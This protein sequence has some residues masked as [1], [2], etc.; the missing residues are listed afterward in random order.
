MYV[1]SRLVTTKPETPRLGAL[2]AWPTLA[3]YVAAIGVAAVVFVPVMLQLDIKLLASWM[4][5]QDIIRYSWLR[6]IFQ[7]LHLDVLVMLDCLSG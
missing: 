3:T 1:A 2:W 5:M 6:R 4:A 7:K